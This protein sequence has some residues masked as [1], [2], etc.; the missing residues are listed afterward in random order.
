[1]TKTEF[2]IFTIIMIIFTVVMLV[3]LKSFDAKLQT[4]NH[5][6]VAAYTEINVLTEQVQGQDKRIA[7]LQQQTPVIEHYH[8]YVVLNEPEREESIA[9]TEDDLYWLAKIIYAEAGYDTDAGQQA[10]AN[11]V[12]NR[13]ISPDFPDTIYDVIWQ[14]TGSVWQFSPCGDGR[15]NL[16]PDERAY[17]NARLVL[18]GLRVLPEDV[19]YFYMPTEGN[20]GDWIRSRE[21]VEKVGVHR[22]CK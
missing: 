21:V 13:V 3:A 4:Y 2:V 5:T 20:R 9:Y 16:E 12:L 14:K 18:E 6:L 17:E 8:G 7:I 19:L 11:V 10:V 1:M 22:F 15:I